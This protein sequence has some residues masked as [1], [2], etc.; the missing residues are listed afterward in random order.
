VTVYKVTTVTML[1]NYIWC[2]PNTTQHTEWWTEYGCKI[3]AKIS[4]LA[5]S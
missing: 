5:H 1:I 3:W 4:L 2:T